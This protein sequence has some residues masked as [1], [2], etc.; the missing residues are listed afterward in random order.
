MLF[1]DNGTPPVSVFMFV[2]NGA[3]SL[4]RAIDSMLS[5][6][7]SNIEFVIQDGAS[8]DGTLEILRSYGDRLKVESV[9]DSGPN[10]GLWR[11]LNRC[12]GTFIASC[13]SDEELLPNSVERAVAVFQQQPIL[14]AVTGDAVITDIDGVHT[15]LWKSGPFNLVDYLLC[16]YTP[17]FCASFFR[18]QALVDAGL[19]KEPWGRDCVEF[20]LWCRL[21]KR[22]RVQYV[23]QTFAKYASHPN[24]STNNSRDASVHF[25]GRLEQIVEMCSAGGFFGEEPLLRTLFVWGHARAFINH[26]ENHNRP[27]MAEALFS[28]A[29][30]VL[31]RFPAIEDSYHTDE[32]SNAGKLFWATLPARLTALLDRTSHRQIGLPMRSYTLPPAADSLTKARMNIHLAQAYEASGRTDEAGE[33][34]R[35]AAILGGLQ[36]LQGAPIVLDKPCYTP[37]TQR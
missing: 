36:P 11:A 16:D 35:T 15:G 26:F 30:K 34:W 32:S 31:A 5:Q 4:R 23:P 21:A 1:E 7:Y 29:S 17:Y 33:A 20:E 8:T 6:T 2:R 10:E 18:R 3:R 25:A 28:I 24:Q 22:S 12:A 19:G 13:L 14:G 27:E 37:A 9:A